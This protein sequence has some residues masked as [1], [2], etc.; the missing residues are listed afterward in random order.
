MQGI[1]DWSR[2]ICT[3]K[4]SNQLFST[5]YATIDE[6]SQIFVLA[7]TRLLLA[8]AFEKY[9]FPESCNSLNSPF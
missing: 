1:V 6:L 3:R 9:S 7:N 2:L 4:Y 5:N 8:F